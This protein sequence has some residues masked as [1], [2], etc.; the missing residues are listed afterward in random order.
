[1]LIGSSGNTVVVM[2]LIQKVAGRPGAPTFAPA[3]LHQ[4]APWHQ[5][6]TPQPTSYAQPQN[7]YQSQQSDFPAL[8]GPQQ[9]QH[10]QPGQHAGNQYAGTQYAQPGQSAGHQYGGNQQQAW[11]QQQQNYQQDQAPA[12]QG[13]GNFLTSIFKALFGK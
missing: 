13:C 10:A 3:A 9:G 11:G 8:P 4:Q 2:Q 1:M 7:G 5:D 12:K 6:Q